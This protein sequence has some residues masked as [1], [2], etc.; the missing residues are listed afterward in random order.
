MLRTTS[1]LS[2]PVL[3]WVSQVAASLG[4]T[5]SATLIWSM[6]P[7][8]GAVPAAPA[9]M[10]SGGKFA[11]RAIE[12]AAYDGLDTMPLPHV[13]P[14]PARFV[15]SAAE[16]APPAILR[17]VAWDE[18]APVERPARAARPARPPVRSEARRPE[19]VPRAAP[20]AVAEAPG[21]RPEAEEGFL[22]RVIPSALPRLL[23]AIASTA[24]DAWTV[25]ASAGDALVSRVVP[26]VP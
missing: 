7:H 4:A 16:L 9:E 2:R 23:P 14:P 20:V 25:T 6:V 26:Q 15:A 19:P 22:H 1:G 3:K 8:P 13:A 11:A 18:A 21:P 5:L 12:P 10:T 17:R 24:R